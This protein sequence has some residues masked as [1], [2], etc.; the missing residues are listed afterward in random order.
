VSLTVKEF[1]FTVCA[2][3][4]VDQHNTSAQAGSKLI[5]YAQPKAISLL[6]CHAVAV[7]WIRF[8]RAD[9]RNGCWSA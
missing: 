8:F 5:A 1:V 7:E 4:A 3:R 2:T 9:T 6:R